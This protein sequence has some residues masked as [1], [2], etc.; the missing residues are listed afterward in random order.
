MD[1]KKVYSMGDI[2]EMYMKVEEV[3]IPKGLDANEVILEKAD[4][5][6]INLYDHYTEVMA[7][8]LPE[9]ICDDGFSR[10]LC[11]GLQKVIDELEK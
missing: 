2:E 3:C 11:E 9:D 8:G 6:T 10:S 1:E 4:S 7:G 5:E